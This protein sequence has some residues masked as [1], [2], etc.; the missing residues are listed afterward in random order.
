[1]LIIAERFSYFTLKRYLRSE[2][3][4]MKTLCDIFMGVLNHVLIMLQQQYRNCAPGRARGACG[5][6]LSFLL[7]R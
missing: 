4:E 6:C 7:H 2:R 5:V 3:C 1:M